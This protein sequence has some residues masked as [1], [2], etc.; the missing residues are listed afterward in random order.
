MIPI[1]AL[2]LALSMETEA[3]E[4]YGKFSVEHPLARDLFLELQTEE[5]KHKKLIEKKIIELTK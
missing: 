4:L 3:I 5:H 2:K 1:E